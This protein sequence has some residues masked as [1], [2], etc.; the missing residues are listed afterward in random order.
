MTTMALYPALVSIAWDYTL[1]VYFFENASPVDLT[2]IFGSILVKA[3]INGT[4]SERI[5][6]VL[7]ALLNTTFLRPE[8]CRDGVG[9]VAIASASP[10]S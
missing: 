5:F 8:I 9:L 7:W 1:S 6:S 4:K 3:K 2:L 10:H